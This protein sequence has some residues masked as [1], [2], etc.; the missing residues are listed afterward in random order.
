M[1]KSNK[2]DK[3]V[4]SFHWE[5]DVEREVEIQEVRE[6][7]KVRDK[8]REKESEKKEDREKESEK[9]EDREITWGQSDLM[10][11]FS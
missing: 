3:K 1:F 9:K 7:K 10:K 6:W 5:W 2:Y 11:I 4:Y 8:D